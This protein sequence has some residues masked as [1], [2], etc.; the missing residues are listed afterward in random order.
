[1]PPGASRT[2]DGQ[3]SLCFLLLPFDVNGVQ[4]QGKGLQ[5]ITFEIFQHISNFTLDG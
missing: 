2:K 4:L 5:H 3:G 1:M